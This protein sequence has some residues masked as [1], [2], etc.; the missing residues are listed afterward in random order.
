MKGPA[1]HMGKRIEWLRRAK[2]MTPEQL[3]EHLGVTP[4]FISQL[5]SGK[6]RTSY[7]HVYKICRLFDISA[8]ELLFGVGSL[9][10]GHAFNGYLSS[11]PETELNFVIKAAKITFDYSF[12]EPEYATLADALTLQAKELA[13]QK[14]NQPK[15][16]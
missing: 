11:L 12:S 14:E 1:A 15:F 5:E 10:E 2:Q 4:G 6:R 13:Q 8:D 16:N 9:T 7:D 3:A